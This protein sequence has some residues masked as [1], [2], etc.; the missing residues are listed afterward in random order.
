[1]AAAEQ[2][3]GLMALETEGGLEL[4]YPARLVEPAAWVGH[5]PFA[6][7]LVGALKPRTIVELG[8]H[9]GNSY[10]AFLQAVRALDLDTRCFGVDHWQG[11]QHASFY[12][13]E[14]YDELRAYHDPLYGTFSTLVR[15]SFEE[16]VHYFSDGTVDLLHIDGFHTYEAV[17]ADFETWLPKVSSRGMALFHDTNVRERGFGIWRFWSELT[18]RYP[19]FEF[20]HAHGLGIVYLGSEPLPG[21]LRAL[22]EEGPPGERGRIQ[23]YFARLGISV[24]ERLAIRTLAAEI[25]TLKTQTRALEAELAAVRSDFAQERADATV[26][27]LAIQTLAAEIDTLKTRRRALDVELAAVRSDF[28][29]ERA[30]ATILA[31][32]LNARVQSLN[33][34][35]SQANTKAALSVELE[36]PH[37][38]FVELHRR[39]AALKNLMAA[40]DRELAVAVKELADY[41]DN[42]LALARDLAFT[43]QRTAELERA[44]ADLELRMEEARAELAGRETEILQRETER[45]ALVTQIE[46]LYASS[47][48]KLAGPLRVLKRSAVRLQ[49]MAAGL[50]GR[51]RGEQAEGKSDEATA[52]P[53]VEITSRTGLENLTPSDAE[54]VRAAFD[55]A[56]YLERYP[57]VRASGIDPFGHYMI[58]GWREHRDPSVDFSTSFYLRCERDIADAGI[59]P[60]VHWVVYGIGEKRQALPFHRRLEREEYTPRVSAI[61]P[62]FNHARFLAQRI[63]SILAQTYPNIDILILDDCSTDESRTI[64]DRYCRNY[65]GR[66]RTLYNEKNSGN[67]FKQWRKGIENTEGEIIWIC[68]S[69]DFCESTFVENLIPHFRD[70]SVRISFG[71]IQETDQHGNLQKGLDEYREGA[72][73]GIWAQSLIRP[74]R[75]WFANG[76]GVNNVI[77]NVGGSLWRRSNIQESVWREAQTYRVVGDW[78]L[79]FHVAGGGQIAWEPE[80]ISY[81]R[82]HSTNTSGASFVQ[83]FFYQ[84]LER[85]MLSLRRQWNVPDITVGKF[86]DKIVNQYNWFNLEPKYGPLEKYCDKRKL[87]ASNRVRPHILMTFLGFIPGGGEFFPINLA[88]HLH[89]SGWLVSMLGFEMIDVN[90]KMREALDPAIAVYDSAWLE[91]YGADRFIAEAGISLIH[92]HTIGSEYRFFEKWKIESNIP[93]LVT[94]HGSYEAS[95]LP[96]DR[97]ARLAAGVSHFVYTAEKN[98]EPFRT[99]ALPRSMFTKLP[100]AMPVDPLPFPKTREDL[101]IAPDAVVYTLV[102]RGIPR[103][104]WASSIAAFIRLRKK[105]PDRALHLLLCGDGGEPDRH[106]ATHGTDPDITFLGYQ[107]RIHGLYRISDVAIVPSR[108]SGESFPLCIIQAFQAGTPVVASR[109]GEIETMLTPR[110]QAPAGI[111]IEPS[112][113]NDLFVRSLEGAMEIMLSKPRRNEYAVAAKI[114]GEGY[115]MDKLVSVYGRLYESMLAKT[116]DGA[117]SECPTAA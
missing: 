87:L 21:P 44:Q 98:L 36:V 9:T 86:H 25:E 103:K 107:S 54:R 108:F 2:Q 34:Q 7:W 27:R 5:V 101:G 113:D 45:K 31:S 47:S 110:D 105:H 89:A 24:V 18:S 23:N 49:S 79:Y 41:A 94:L 14:I 22:F 93:Y 16:A 96:N 65:S 20:S 28:A 81:F 11:D 42:K 104:G 50:F 8:V 35:L 57:D 66:I 114:L 52:S 62:N 46:A 102:A 55:R 4:E 48:W 58:F 10:C 90:V 85:F 100:N 33:L 69:D 56:Y 116:T 80:A 92:S 37:T 84:E 91:E 15:S 83:P 3:D 115:S 26:E 117:E 32:N 59:N 71:R 78:F 67:V 64:I 112:E 72:E 12:G 77:A 29:R 99:A 60:F 38:A 74:A 61:V 70:R 6:F 39:H 63:E 40:R 1:M 76:F 106:F 109:V 82:R 97:Y 19:N 88:N 17:S 73:P 30:D 51:A 43:Q 53:E 111:L 75:Q 13:G 95:E 68:E